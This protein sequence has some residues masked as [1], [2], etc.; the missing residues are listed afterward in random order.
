MLQASCNSSA[1]H[2]GSH[3]FTGWGR[4]FAMVILVAHTCCA[5]NRATQCRAH[6]VP[7]TSRGF[8]DVA[9]MSRSTPPPP[10]HHVAPVFPPPVAIVFGVFWRERRLGVTL[11]V[12]HWKCQKCRGKISFRKWIALHEGVA[13]TLTPIALHCATTM[14]IGQ[15]P[16]KFQRLLSRCQ[17]P[18][19]ICPQR[20]GL[21]GF[22]WIW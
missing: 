14:V 5:P 6:I 15:R 1:S 8:R 13:T 16:S 3:L 18:L 10:K 11:E 2:K 19:T 21:A 9:G 20:W 12:S 22:E 17:I 4:G 7:A